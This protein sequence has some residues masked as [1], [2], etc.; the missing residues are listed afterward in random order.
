MTALKQSSGLLQQ[1][2]AGATRRAAASGRAGDTEAYVLPAQT[3]AI[4]AGTAAVERAQAPYNAAEIQAGGEFADRPIEPGVF[5]YLTELG[6]VSAQYG[7]DREYLEAMKKYGGT[8]IAGTQSPTETIKGNTM[9]F[10][11]DDGGEEVN[12]SLPRRKRRRTDLQLNY[13]GH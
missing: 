9:N 10:Y 3:R 6:G 13:G 11:P 8:T 7:Q 5:D 4:Q 2:T 1:A 12:L